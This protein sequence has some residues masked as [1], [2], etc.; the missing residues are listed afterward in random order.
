LT[1]AYTLCYNKIN[2]AELLFYESHTALDNEGNVVPIDDTELV[3]SHEIDEEHQE[4]DDIE[5]AKGHLVLA[6]L[7][8]QET[9]QESILDDNEKN[10]L[11]AELCARIAADVRSMREKG[12]A[13]S[14]I[15][16]LI[17][18]NYGSQIITT[19]MNPE[20]R[21]TG[22]EILKLIEISEQKIAP[23]KGNDSSWSD[24]A[25]RQRRIREEYN[26][27]NA[28]GRDAAYKDN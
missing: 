18:R 20:T 10:L 14:R 13:P 19:I 7:A 23:Q 16:R 28:V 1:K 21:E 17:H 24:W 5:R 6:V 3:D 9:V 25:E 4:R 8:E 2:M 22:L 11:G 15:A 12:Y 26:N 27:G